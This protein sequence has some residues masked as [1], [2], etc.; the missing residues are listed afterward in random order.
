MFLSG[1]LNEK[2]PFFPYVKKVEMIGQILF[3]KDF[4]RL[5]IY[6]LLMQY[7]VEHAVLIFIQ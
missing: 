2:T 1:Q 7:I 6:M 5:M 3:K 4:Y